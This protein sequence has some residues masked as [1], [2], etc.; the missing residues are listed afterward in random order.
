MCSRF[1]HPVHD[2]AIS[3]KYLSISAL[4]HRSCFNY[5]PR[6]HAK[7]GSRI[8]DGTKTPVRLFTVCG[9]LC[10]CSPVRL[11]GSPSGRTSPAYAGQN[12]AV[13][14]AYPAPA[15]AGI[16][17]C[18]PCK[19]R[20]FARGGPKLFGPPNPRSPRAASGRGSITYQGRMQ[21][22]KALELTPQGFLFLLVD[23]AGIE[24]ASANPLLPVLH[25]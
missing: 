24:P 22:Q 4:R 21:K 3:S 9:R 12:E 18:S 15:P 11:V 2:C 17:L 16:S 1:I 10:Q 5:L 19:A 23:P 8:T 6:P 7:T 25:A 13:R 14:S 20:P